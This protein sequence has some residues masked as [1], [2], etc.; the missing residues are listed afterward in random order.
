[1]QTEKKSPHNEKKLPKKDTAL[2]QKQPKK[3]FAEEGIEMVPFVAAHGT[4]GLLIVKAGDC[5]I[6]GST[7]K[8][9]L[10]SRPKHQIRNKKATAAF[11]NP[12]SKKV[13]KIPSKA[14]AAT[15]KKSIRWNLWSTKS[16]DGTQANVEGQKPKSKKPA[17]STSRERPSTAKKS[18]KI[19]NGND[20][21][22]RQREAPGE[23]MNAIEKFRMHA[24][25]LGIS[26]K[27]LLDAVS[28]ARQETSE[29]SPI[30]DPPGSFSSSLYS[31]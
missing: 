25:K 19:K 2:R 23:V 31:L 6:S 11:Q 5:V 7:P 1:M 22:D 28:E 8:M 9:P 12:K 16:P 26:G 3:L 24:K 14:A 10:S 27:E 15:A 13:T 29:L 4:R 21:S 30:A 18:G 20:K 17:A